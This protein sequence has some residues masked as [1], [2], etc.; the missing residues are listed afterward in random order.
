MQWLLVRNIIE[1][2]SAVL[3]FVIGLCVC[4]S[5]AEWR[6]FVCGD[7]LIV[8]SFDDHVSDGVVWLLVP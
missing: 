4:G 1:V 3:C 7:S 8:T 6:E 5:F 2:I